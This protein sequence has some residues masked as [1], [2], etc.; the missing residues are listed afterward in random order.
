MDQESQD[1]ADMYCAGF[2]NGVEACAEYLEKLA[3]GE[4]SNINSLLYINIAD[5]FRK[6]VKLD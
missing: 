1:L 6:E 4:I 2:E 5:W 3:N